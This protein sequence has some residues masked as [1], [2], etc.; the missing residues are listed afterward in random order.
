M[1][2]FLRHYVPTNVLILIYYSLIYSFLIYGIEIWGH[3]FPT[4]LKPISRLQK[5]AVRLITF[6]D[7]QSHSEPIFKFLNLIKFTDTIKFQ[8]IKFIFQWKN[9]L[10]PLSFD[11]F[12]ETIKEIHTYNT[13]QASN[14]NI[15][16]ERRNTDQYGKRTIKF[17]GAIL[18][19][20]IP[21]DLKNCT[22]ITTF[23]RKLKV[24]LIDSYSY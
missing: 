9:S 6:S 12:F 22:S 23:K 2:F 13:R 5:K 3:T 16:L 14:D 20:S 4:Y 8:T 21:N 10:L 24:Y 17:A 15:Y 11:N 19:N 7:Y 18:W 1:A